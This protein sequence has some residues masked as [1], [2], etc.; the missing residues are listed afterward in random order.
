MVI[1]PVNG[2]EK[3]RGVGDPHRA[4]GMVLLQGPRGRQFLSEVPL[5][6][7]ACGDSTGLK[8]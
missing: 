4:L 6:G 5:L 3:G 7:E 2:E 8:T 1:Q